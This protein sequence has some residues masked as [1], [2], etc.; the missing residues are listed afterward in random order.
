VTDSEL[1]AAQHRV[2]LNMP[3][4]CQLP[5]KHS[6]PTEKCQRCRVIEMYN[7]RAEYESET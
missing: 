5:W 2:I 7:E 6:A 1:L 4:S 3:C